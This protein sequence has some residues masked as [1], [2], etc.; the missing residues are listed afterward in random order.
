MPVLGGLGLGLG[1]GLSTVTL[2]LALTRCPYSERVWLAL[3]HKG[4]AY[5]TVLIDNTG[6]GRPSWYSGDT[7]QVRWPDGKQQKESLAIV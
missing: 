5:E 1:L 6:G 4:I 2:T 7:P 3:E